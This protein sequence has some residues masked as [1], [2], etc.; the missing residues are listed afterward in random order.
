MLIIDNEYTAY[1]KKQQ[2]FHLFFSWGTFSFFKLHDK[3]RIFFFN[4][5]E[6]GI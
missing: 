5:K 6:T 2:L 3:N 1:Y 4:T